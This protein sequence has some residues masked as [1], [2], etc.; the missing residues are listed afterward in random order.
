MDLRLGREDCVDLL[1]RLHKEHPEV[2][3]LVFSMHGGAFH[4]RRAL[5][6]GALGY[7]TKQEGTEQ[8]LDAIRLLMQGKPF[9]SE[10]VRA[11]SDC[12]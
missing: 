2:K 4:V 5:Q 10:T 9:L 8:V 3:L 6:A 1:E 7:V 12:K 11:N